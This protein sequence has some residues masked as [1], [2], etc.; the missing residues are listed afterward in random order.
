MYTSTLSGT[1]SDWEVVIT[2]LK[3]GVVGAGG[4]GARH[5]RVVAES[6][7]ADL[8]IVVDT[9]AD[10]AAKVAGQ[11]GAANGSDLD[12]LAATCDAAIIATPTEHHAGTA[13]P[14]LERGVPLLIEKPIAESAND[15]NRILL[16]SRRFGGPVMCGFVERFNPALVAA[17]EI[18][19]APVVHMRSARH[20]PHNPGAS[21][22]I[23]Q[24]LLIHDIDLALRA[25]GDCPPPTVQGT[26]WVPPE[27]TRSEVSEC[28]L[29]FGDRMVASLSA[30]R[31][32]QRKIR[33]VSFAT[34]E[35]LFEVDL[36]RVNVTVYRN[37]SQSLA[38]AGE[39]YR[40]QTVVDVPFVRHRGE[41]LALQF[42]AF[43]DLVRSG[44]DDR[45][46]IERRSIL[47]AHEIAALMD[48][49]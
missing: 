8:A 41:P 29:R 45:A 31:W 25:A 21:S 20:S 36:L 46:E 28:V 4:M 15:V 3:V 17:M 5:A 22:T 34:D 24:D 23:V 18:I 2:R 49:L 27:S 43:V 42:A 39:A 40:A 26:C 48:G 16:A 47:P 14:L 19:D 11:F 12:A 13:L 38:T 33:E 6:D 37:V 10:R 35:E 30:S 32:G 44:D 9:D 1:S 7:D